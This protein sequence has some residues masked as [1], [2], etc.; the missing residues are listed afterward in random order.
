MCLVG[1]GSFFQL[2]MTSIE[3]LQ[4]RKDGGR[5]A[6]IW[7]GHLP[8]FSA[9]TSRMQV[10]CLASTKYKRSLD[11]TKTRMHLH[12]RQ[13]HFPLGKIKVGVNGATAAILGYRLISLV[14]AVHAMTTLKVIGKK[15][16]ITAAPSKL[17]MYSKPSLH[18]AEFQ[19]HRSGTIA[20]HHF[21]TELGLH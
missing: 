20:L 2:V 11:P 21:F 16:S 17:C 4:E 7:I 5:R 12:F 13:T 9:V 19:T 18:I 15:L 6:D 8:N 14:G 1:G 3:V 10:L